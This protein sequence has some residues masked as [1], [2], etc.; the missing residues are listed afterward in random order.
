MP[1]SQ[2][3]SA[4][5]GQGVIK[6]SGPLVIA[7]DE[8]DLVPLTIHVVLVQRGAYAHG[9][10]ESGGGRADPVL[11]WTLDAVTDGTIF[12]TGP[13]LASGL[14]VFVDRGK[15][16]DVPLPQ[17]FTWTEQVDIR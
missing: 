17:T 8:G 11:G 3:D 4:V 16:G 14:K 2:I 9:H 7:A 6:V 13:A 15:A 12:T 1:R 10:G 5:L